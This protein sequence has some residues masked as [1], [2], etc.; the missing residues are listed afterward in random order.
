MALIQYHTRHWDSD[1]DNESW[2]LWALR[3]AVSAAWLLDCWQKP[4]WRDYRPSHSTRPAVPRLTVTSGCQ[5]S[6]RADWIAALTGPAVNHAGWMSLLP[7]LPA[8]TTT[9]TSAS[10]TA[11]VCVFQ[12]RWNIKLNKCDMLLST[13]LLY[14]TKCQLIFSKYTKFHISITS[15]LLVVFV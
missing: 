15:L 9:T 14:A 1:T 4:L 3:R 5:L 13:A 10:T 11:T 6:H 7:A 2:L 8:M 12:E